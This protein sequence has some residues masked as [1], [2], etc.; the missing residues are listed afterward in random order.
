MNIFAAAQPH[1]R[2]AAARPHD[3]FAAARRH[4]VDGQVRTADVTDL[5]ILAAMSEIPRERFLPQELAG[6]AYLDLDVPVS[7]TRR[8]LKSMVF[9]KLVQA[10]DL[11]G[12]ERVLDVGAVGGYGAA[13]LARLAGHVV[14]LEEDENLAPSAQAALADAPNV[15]AAGGPLAAGWPQAAP[16]DAILLEGAVEQVPAA[17]F[18]QLKD[19]GRLACVVGGGPSAKATLYRRSGAD[20]GGRAIFDAAAAVLPGFVKPPAFAF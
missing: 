15:T 9:A 6:L 18:E 1:D 7:A 13:V 12:E 16:Y 3:A 20:V 11:S 4:M 14:A 17:L 8:L 19:G 2:S 5:R 10:L